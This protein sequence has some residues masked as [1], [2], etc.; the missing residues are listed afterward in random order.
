MN[1]KYIV[2]LAGSPRGGK[3]TWNSLIKNV[4]QPLD[5]DLAICL[6]DDALDETLLKDTA[7]YIWTFEEPKNWKDYYS[8]NFSGTNWLDYFLL[9]TKNGMA[10]GIDDNPGSGSIVC[11]LKNIIHKNYLDI[12]EKY[13]YVIYSRFDQF[14]TDIHPKFSGDHLWIPEGEDYF[15]VC[16]RHI[17]FPSKYS[18]KYFGICDYINDDE[19][20]KN[21]PKVVNPE[22]VFLNYLEFTGLEKKIIRINRFNF[23]SALASDST[24]W[25][26]ASYKVYFYRNLMMKYPDEFLLSVKTLINKYSLIKNIFTNSRLLINYYYL[27]SRQI[28]G[29][30]LKKS[31]Q[32]NNRV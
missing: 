4:L 11:A 29:K 12:L 27:I 25:R 17:I 19:S 31:P 13:D 20:F 8:N 18:K 15:G 7:K 14:Y 3:A 9:G 28:L 24:R 16:D 22:A 1:N 30:I 2:V 32:T 10:G 26:V 6:A 5:A 21:L 23:T